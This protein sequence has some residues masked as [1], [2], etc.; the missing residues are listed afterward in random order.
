[1]RRPE[2]ICLLLCAAA[3]AGAGLLRL[4]V[5]GQGLAFP[6][7]PEVW[8]LRLTRLGS[9]LVVGAALGL[10]GLQLQ[11]LL[12][13]PLASPDL[14]GLASGAG[15]GVTLSAYL[16]FLATGAIAPAAVSSSA[17]LAGAAGAL[18]VVY[19]LSARGGL[20]DPARLILVGVVVALMASA[21]SMF[22]E[23]LLPDRGMASRRWLLGALRDDARAPEVLGVGL[24]AVVALA[25]TA[26]LGPSMDAASLDEH[27]AR[28]VGVRLGGLRVFLFASA[29]VL[30]AASVTLAG[31]VGFVGLIAPHAVRRIA[32][33]GHRVGAIGSA[34]LGA[35][36]VVAADALVKAIDLGGG[37]LPI[38]VLTSLIGGPVLI[39]LIRRE[40]RAGA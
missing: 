38:G 5:G 17:A 14:L 29:A 32:G 35:G 6:A 10:A 40:Q 30:T 22:V 21:A 4:L 8:D 27:E 28:S 1:M 34:L 26:R 2:V 39:W 3:C 13:N 33:P 7:S 15:L 36:L 24:A 25:V 37:R 23:H 19:A 12:R 18:L 9:G 11:C 31:P 20:I 16:G